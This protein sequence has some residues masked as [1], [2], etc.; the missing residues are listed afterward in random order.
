[1]QATEYS[2]ISVNQWLGLTPKQVVKDHLHLSDNVLNSFPKT[3]PI[4]VPGNPNLTRTN[5]A[6]AEHG[7]A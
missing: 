6:P 7:G 3:K 1:L 5:F 2:D 4:I